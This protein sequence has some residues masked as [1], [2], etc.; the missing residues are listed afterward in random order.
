M[1]LLGRGLIV[2]TENRLDTYILPGVSA[3]GTPNTTQIN[4][5][6][7]YF[8]NL[9]FGPTE[10]RIYDASV[11]R[12]QEVSLAYRFPQKFLDR[13]PFGSLV[14][15]VQGFNLWYDAYNTPDGANFDPNVQGVGVGNGQGFD[16]LN[17]PS[18]RRY[19][20]TVKASF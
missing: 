2:E 5:S 15:T 19:G 16:F 10:T 7:Y 14:F 18:A 12:L 4:N 17:G 9:L 11:I 20:F 6:Q 8:S 13:T 3:S 1:S